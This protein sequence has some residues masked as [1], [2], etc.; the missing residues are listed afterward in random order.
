MSEPNLDTR[1]KDFEQRL[2]ILLKISE[3]EIKLAECQA[4][5]DAAK[6]E[7][8]QSRHS[9][10]RW[11]STLLIM[12]LVAL[13]VTTGVSIPKAARTAVDDEMKKQA[14]VELTSRLRNEVA[15]AEALRGR[16]SAANS[17]LAQAILVFD[18]K[19]VADSIN[20]I[21]SEQN[22]MRC[23]LATLGSQ[24]SRIAWE[25]ATPSAQSHKE[26]MLARRYGYATETAFNT[27]FSGDPVKPLDQPGTNPK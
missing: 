10:Q 12:A 1:L 9:L 2:D 25:A 4:S 3:V 7:F 8:A 18:P 21:N 11:F 16:L 5:V 26:F 22:D 27:K 17:S 13:G 14:N 15:E 24:I 19:K 6:G 20:S 23:H